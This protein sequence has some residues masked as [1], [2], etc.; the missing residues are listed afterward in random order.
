MSPLNRRA[1]LGATAVLLAAPLAVE[2]QPTAKMPRI[3]VLR[4]LSPETGAYTYALRDG[5]SALGYVEGHNI[6][7]EWRWAHG[8]NER[9]AELAA[10]L[11]RLKLDLIVAGTERSVLTM[12][13]MAPTSPII[14]VI[15]SDPVVDGFV[16]KIGRAH[17]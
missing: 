1:F 9:L 13:K 16:T 7:I 15:L 11:S 5:L 14:F 12:Q 17:V 6:A 4:N 2:A 8:S 10:E 3:G